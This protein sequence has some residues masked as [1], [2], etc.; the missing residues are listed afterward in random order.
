VKELTRKDLG[1]KHGREADG[2]EAGRVWLH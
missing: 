1:L 2:F